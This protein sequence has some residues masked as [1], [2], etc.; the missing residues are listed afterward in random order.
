LTYQ[1][2]RRRVNAT[3]LTGMGRTRRPIIGIRTNAE[4]QAQAAQEIAWRARW[5]GLSNR[6]AEE[7]GKQLAETPPR[8]N[9]LEP[10]SADPATPRK[11]HRRGHRAP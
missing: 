11:P 9:E 8:P 5:A 4:A 2:L 6:G 1:R 10:V 7:R 3:I